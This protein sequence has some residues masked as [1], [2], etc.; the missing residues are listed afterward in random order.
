MG[1]H[2]WFYKKIKTPPFEEMKKVVIDT[3]QKSVD[4]LTNWIND[5]QC[6]EYQ[7]MISAYPEWDI[8]FISNW[9]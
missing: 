7:Q 9:R 3:Y 5:P 8:P 6:D 4:D 1:C 2:T